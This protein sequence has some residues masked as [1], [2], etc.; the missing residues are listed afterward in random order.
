MDKSRRLK[1][2]EWGLLVY[3]GVCAF[4]AGI[5]L[6]LYVWHS[7]KNLHKPSPDDNVTFEM[8]ET[9]VNDTTFRLEEMFEDRSSALH[10]ID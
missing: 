7:H 8:L 9:L 3:E 10:R 1:K 6:S 2:R 4:A 5:A